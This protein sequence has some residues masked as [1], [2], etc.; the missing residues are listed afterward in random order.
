MDALARHDPAQ[1][2]PSVTRPDPTAGVVC[3]GASDR[4][5]SDL[6]GFG[7]QRD[8]YVEAASIWRRRDH[9]RS[10]LTFR[11][12]RQNGIRFMAVA[13]QGVGP[14]FDRRTDGKRTDTLLKIAPLFSYAVESHG[15]WVTVG[16]PS[17][18]VSLS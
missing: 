12:L 11:Q 1:P 4:T 16:E 17:D 18:K 6:L 9:P 8:A 15:S 7:V 3:R 2:D 10:G 14:A 13:L 5:G